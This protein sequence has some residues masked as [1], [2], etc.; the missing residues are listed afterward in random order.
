MFSS[1]PLALIAALAAAVP[2]LA[3]P[4]RIP[5][6]N[7]GINGSVS[8][9]DIGGKPCLAIL[10]KPRE[11]AGLIAWYGPGNLQPGDRKVG[12]QFY[13]MGVY[14]P[15][16]C[17]QGGTPWWH[18]TT[19]IDGS[20]P[21]C[22]KA[23]SGLAIDPSGYAFRTIAPPSGPFFSAVGGLNIDTWRIDYR[24]ID[25][26]LQAQYLTPCGSDADLLQCIVVEV[27]LR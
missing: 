2:A 21:Y 14:D 7:L 11:F 26:S 1:R 13:W 15:R 6:F 27:A 4:P 23:V 18:W 8:V 17:A 5:G 25:A 22:W 10:G 19:D 24:C 20:M 9:I 16:P 12:L 3:Q